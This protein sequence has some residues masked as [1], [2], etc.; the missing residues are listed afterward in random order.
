MASLNCNRVVTNFQKSQDLPSNTF[1]LGESFGECAESDRTI[2]PSMGSKL[3]GFH[4]ETAGTWS[5]PQ[6]GGHFAIIYAGFRMSCMQVL[7]FTVMWC[8]CVH[9]W[10]TRFACAHD[11]RRVCMCAFVNDNVCMCTWCAIYIYIYIYIHIYIYIMLCRCI[12]IRRFE[13]KVVD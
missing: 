1:I 9:L 6:Y 13:L 11:V 7:V 10:T 4:K 8:A 3:Y 2:H 12:D 5:R